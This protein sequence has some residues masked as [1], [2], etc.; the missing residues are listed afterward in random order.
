MMIRNIYSHVFQRQNS[1]SFPSRQTG[2]NRK[3]SNKTRSITI[4]QYHDSLADCIL[5]LSK[6]QRTISGEVVLTS[7]IL[8]SK[9]GI[10]RSLTR[11]SEITFSQ[12]NHQ[13]KFWS[14]NLFLVVWWWW[15]WRWWWWL[16]FIF[17]SKKEGPE[18]CLR[19][20]NYRTS[21][22]AYHSA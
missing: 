19:T 17:C 1:C 14:I 15:R 12:R 8:T 13:V 18:N 3:N 16:K 22:V 20:L 5:V 2:K 6:L 4:K 9:Y 10:I 7:L 21:A 11:V